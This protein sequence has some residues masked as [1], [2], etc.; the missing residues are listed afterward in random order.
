MLTDVQA[1]PITQIQ[2]VIVCAKIRA[3]ESKQC[4]VSV[5]PK[6]ALLRPQIFNVAATLFHQIV[7]D[8]MQLTVMPHL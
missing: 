5:A 3:I 1:W 7:N 6:V 4:Y 8:F 2:Y